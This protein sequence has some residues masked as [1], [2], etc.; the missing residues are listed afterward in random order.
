M[1]CLGR[2][3][4]LASAP[5]ALASSLLEELQQVT[6]YDSGTA[7]AKDEYVDVPL[8]ISYNEPD[9]VTCKICAWSVTHMWPYPFLKTAEGPQSPPLGIRSAPQLGGVSAG[10]IEL[11]ADGSFREWTILNA[12][13]AGSGKYGLVD[14]VW[15]AVRAGRGKDAAAKVLR[16]HPPAYLAGK[17]V[18][19]L[20]FSGTYPVT[21][22][23]VPQGELLEGLDMSLFAYSTLR[24]TD[25]AGSAYP[26][27][28][29]TLVAENTGKEPV[30]LSLMLQLPM[31]A[32]TD[33][34]RQGDGKAGNS[35]AASHVECLYAC[36]ENK[37]CQSWHFNVARKTCR[38]NSDVPLTAHSVG[39]YCGVRG[40]G[41]HA[42]GEAISLSQWPVPNSQS[43]SAGSVTL[44]PVSGTTSF[45]AGDDPVKMFQDFE[46]KG[47]LGQ[48]RL[49][50]TVSAYSAASVLAS[51]PA[52]AKGSVSIVFAWHFP[53]RDFSG[54][55][56]GNAYTNL[57]RDS[58]EV[59]SA[60]ADESV[61]RRVVADINK[62]HRVVASV[63]NP[64]PVW[65][66]DMLV[67][68]WAQM[69]MM[70]WFKDSRIRFYESYSCDD[71]DS[72]HNDYQR[73]L[74]YLWAYPEHETQK[75]E[76]WGTFALA[77]DGHVQEALAY[78]GKPMDRP[79]GRLMGDTTSLWLLE[80]YEHW[81]NTGDLELARRL[82]PSAL[83]GLDWMLGNAGDFGLPQF[84]E[85][86]YDHFGWHKQHSVVY[87]AHIYLAT[88]QAVQRLA[89]GLGDGASAEKAA[90][91]Y[92]VG[93]AAVQREF[94][95]ASSKFFRATA[96]QNQVFTDSLYGQ[97]LAHHN[98]GELAFNNSQQL[99]DHLD[100]EWKQNQDQFGMRVLNHP[101]QE[102][103]IWMNG[104]PT[105]SYLELLQGKLSMEEAL[106]PLKRMSENIRTNLRDTWNL[107]A[108]LHT[109]TAKRDIDKGK[110]MEQGHYA[111]M[112]TDLFL[113][114][115]L[116]G[117]RVDMANAFS[118]HRLEIVPMFKPPFTLPIMLSGCEASLQAR[119]A[120][121]AIS[122]TL[123]VAFGR[124]R[125]PAGG[126]RVCGQSRPEA[127]FLREDDSLT[128]S[129]DDVSGCKWGA[130]QTY[131]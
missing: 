11:R 91:A 123:T 37:L 22:L 14:D 68:Q 63:D 47:D 44:R 12:G 65:L 2:L 56:L 59:A 78:T 94:W 1:A 66:K 96:G 23:E 48:T 18:S 105:W 20:T 17:G 122:F 88:L 95:N 89:K 46:A 103:S 126:L 117:M 127:I 74:L 40:M 10:S 7:T 49:P 8:P 125:L 87:N 98:F 15:M 100:Y 53:N 114:P 34:S 82:W 19:Q 128:W 52:G 38:L 43:P 131:I 62:H 5:T 80:I 71:V 112:L 92:E 108:L 79:G 110:P 16:T 25:L 93:L 30:D 61:L 119:Q 85:T 124:L 77:P 41:W 102:D 86:T 13:P 81:R 104:P 33:C 36:H 27:V 101:I 107:R 4:L 111:F 90:R 64:T 129:Q 120:N 60:L 121:G 70:M 84:V 39:S 73:H 118:E 72:V 45:A 29:L 51:I 97:M 31:A 9:N 26:A 99:W 57:W 58:N 42:D 130:V 83:R 54:E 3:L 76:A 32:M 69:H 50:S 109:Q 106:E 24:P 28:V 55:V 113:L 115:L 6:F 116:S 75:L 35:S 67:N 21:K